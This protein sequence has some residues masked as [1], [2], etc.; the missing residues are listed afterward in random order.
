MEPTD[1]N[2]LLQSIIDGI[3]SEDFEKS[4]F[5]ISDL[6]MALSMPLADPEVGPII[7]YRPKKMSMGAKE[8]SPESTKVLNGL[9]METDYGQ[10]A[11]L[12]VKLH[13]LILS[14]GFPKQWETA[15]EGEF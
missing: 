14:K 13:F 3:K 1:T 15:P 12:F 10:K 5:L 7:A 9:R 6:D 11:L 4:S 2:K 8:T